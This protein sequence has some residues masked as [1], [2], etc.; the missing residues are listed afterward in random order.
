VPRDLSAIRSEW[1]ISAS[2]LRT[3]H[4][5]LAEHYA[6]PRVRARVEASICD[7]LA[8]GIN[9]E[10]VIEGVTSTVLRKVAA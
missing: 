1:T 7:V 5:A 4:L 8:P 9:R 6:E 10:E 3:R 2:G